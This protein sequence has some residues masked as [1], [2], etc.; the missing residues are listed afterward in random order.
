MGGRSMERPTICCVA[1]WW[2]DNQEI[3]EGRVLDLDS[4]HGG[5]EPGLIE[6]TQGGACQ[7]G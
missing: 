1:G 2:E 5:F 3:L 7:G 6:W 4:E